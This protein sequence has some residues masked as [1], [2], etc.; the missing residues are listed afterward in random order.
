MKLKGFHEGKTGSIQCV[1]LLKV[2]N[3]E[4][5]QFSRQTLNNL[6]KPLEANPRLTTIVLKGSKVLR[7][8]FEDLESV[9]KKGSLWYLIFI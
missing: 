4:T 1:K 3:F 2:S 8:I 9:S 5:F 7:N 6:T